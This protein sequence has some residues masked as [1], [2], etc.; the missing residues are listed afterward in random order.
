MRV[1]EKC[2]LRENT[3]IA[4]RRSCENAC[5]LQKEFVLF[6]DYTNIVYSSRTYELVENT[7]NN[8]L[9]KV[10]QSLCY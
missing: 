6:A 1:R 4:K 8:G 5:M 9:D 2:G 3:F 10:N 7:V